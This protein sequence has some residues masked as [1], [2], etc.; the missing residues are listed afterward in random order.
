MV[1]SIRNTEKALSIFKKSIRPSEKPNLKV[2][3]KSIVAKKIL[4]GEFLNE[5]NLTTK[6]PK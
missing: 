6:R 1:N 4:K 3:R 2:V 5:S